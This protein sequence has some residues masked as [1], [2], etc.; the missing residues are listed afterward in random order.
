MTVTKDKNVNAY[1][2]DSL[3]WP[4]WRGRTNEWRLVTDLLRRGGAGQGG[5]LLVEGRSG[6]GKTQ[7]LSEAVDAAASHGIPALRGAGDVA[8][9]FTPVAPLLSMLGESTGSLLTLGG[10]SRTDVADLRSFLVGQIS[11]RLEILSMRGPLLLTLD[12]LHWADPTTLFAL[13]SILTKVLS[14]PLVWILGRT[15][16]SGE[17]ALDQLYDVLER[18]GATRITLES[19]DEAAVA[20]IAS[21]FFGAP[22]DPGLLAAAAQA[23]G[24]PFLLVELF[25]ALRADN[26]V[27]VEAGRSQLAL[28]HPSGQF[29]MPTLNRLQTLS[30]RTRRLLQVAAVL[31]RSF[32]VDDLA[33]IRGEPAGKLM[34]SLEEAMASEVLIPQGD[35]LAFRHD[36]L[37]QA[38][39]DSLTVP[40]RQALHREAAKMLLSRGGSTVPAAVH[41]MSYARP[42]ETGA[43]AALDQAASEVLSYCPQTAADLAVRALELTNICDPGW[44]NRAMTAVCALS[45]AGQLSEAAELCTTALNQSTRPDHAARARY[46]RANVLLLAGQPKQAAAEAE[47]VLTTQ[48]LPTDLRGLAEYVAFLA[49]SCTHTFWRGREDAERVLAHPGG[50]DISAVVGAHILLTDIAWG[51][52]RALD[53]LEH[54]REAVRLADAGPIRIQH[55][56]P[57]FYLAIRLLALRQFEEAEA[58]LH[59]LAERIDALGN[60]AQAVSPA[61]ARS[62]LGLDAGHFDDAV[63]EAHAALAMADEMGMHMY[64]LLALAVLAIAA[65]RRG[66]ADA[67]AGYSERLQE[68]HHVLGMFGLGW[69]KAA[70]AVVAEAYGS[71]GRAKKV[72]EAAFTDPREQRWMLMIES[73]A[74]A[75]MVRVSLATGDRPRAEMVSAT[76]DDLARTNPDF[77][78]LAASAAHARG[79]L[80]QD[81]TALAQAAATHLDPWNAASAAEDLGVLLARTTGHHDAERRAAVHSLEQALEGYER[82]G[83]HRDTARARAR[84]RDLGVRRRHWTYTARPTTGWESL[85]KTESQVATLVAQGMTNRQTATQLYLSPHT[86]SFHLRG[87]FRKL[88]IT[89]RVELAR[90]VAERD[91]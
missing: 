20:G 77:T 26:A 80:R 79:I 24:N 62:L 38:M 55:A 69:A 73:N 31:G 6:M 18:D 82:I 49:L 70:V 15:T 28:T 85:T 47:H 72:L 51:E 42:G 3:S 56:H 4:G 61:I 2:D 11:D 81:P 48:D 67:A 27:A 34:R 30:P 41:L 5:V 88:G 74:A 37:W 1:D 54:T 58:A 8:R 78:A 91:S 43:V 68:Q 33:E 13:R 46:E 25:T 40:I 52:G 39:I 14:C 84:L 12:D 19:L 65:V 17:P 90:L 29:Q 50:R 83:A 22:P 16:G 63:A 57:R 53:A 60:T 7:L 45:S 89:S 9:Q 75:W 76:A 87:V 59:A 66:D 23:G 21:D 71:P 44:F 32:S 35:L 64:D 10:I 36:L 86:V